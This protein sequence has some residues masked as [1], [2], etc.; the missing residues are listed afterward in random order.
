MM[1]HIYALGTLSVEIDGSSYTDQLPRKALALL[2]Y[3]A[4]KGKPQSRDTL[5]EL[6][7]PDQLPERASGSLRAILTDLR[8]FLAPYLV[9]SR[10]TVELATAA[11]CWIDV[12]EF[13]QKTDNFQ[14]TRAQTN[15]LSDETYGA[16]EQALELVQGE[17][18]SGFL[19]SNNNEFE[20]W[21]VE[22]REWIRRQ[23]I[24][25]GLELIAMLRERGNPDR[26]IHWARRL[27]R[28]D[29]L[30]E[31]THQQMMR[32]L[33]ESGARAAALDHYEKLR[34]QLKN[35]LDVEPDSVTAALYHAIRS[36]KF[37]GTST[38]QI[39][40]KTPEPAPAIE[41]RLPTQHYPF[42]G[43][44]R[45][46]SQIQTLLTSKSCRLL[47]LAGSG[48]IGKTRLAIETGRQLSG[49]FPDGVY[50]VPLAPVNDVEIIP[51]TIAEA[52]RV[53]HPGRSDI[54]LHLFNFLAQ[55]SLLLILDNFE[56]LMDASMLVSEILG[57]APQIKC[58][59]TSRERLGLMEE[60]TLGVEGMQFPDPGTE[61]ME[62][63]PSLEMFSQAAQRINPAFALEPELEAVARICQLVQG[64]PLGIE[65]AAAWVRVMEPAE[66][67]RHIG[68]NVDFLTSTLRNIPE[69]H[70]SMRAI[71]EWSWNLLTMDE[72]DLLRRL[73]IFRGGFTLA[74]V[75]EIIDKPQHV[76]LSLLNSLVEKSL[77]HYQSQDVRYS[78][79][80]LLRQFAEEK[81]HTEPAL[82]AEVEAGH[83]HYYATFMKERETRLGGAIHHEIIQEAVQ[84]L[85]NVR[86][87][88]KYS[89]SRCDASL[90]LMLVRS[91]F[92]VYEGQSMY[93]E[94]EAAFRAAKTC[95]RNADPQLKQ[96]V[97]IRATLFHGF[98]LYMMNRYPEARTNLDEAL[99][100]LQSLATQD[101]SILWDLRLALGYTAAMNYAEGNFV[102]ARRYYEAEVEIFRRTGQ[103]T[104][105]GEPLMRLSDIAVVMG[106]YHHARQII[107]ENLPLFW[108]SSSRRSRVLFLTTLGDIDCKLGAF[109]EAK[110]HFEEAL[111]L[112]RAL[113]YRVNTGVALVSLG[114]VTYGLGEYDQAES[115][116]HESLQIFEEVTHR[117][118]ISFART[119][120]GRVLT[121]IG[122]FSE[123]RGN[124]L[125]SLSI[126]QE[127]R[128]RWV[129]CF[130]LRQFAE[131]HAQQDDWEQTAHHLQMALSIAYEINVLPLILDTLAG[132]AVCLAQSGLNSS[133][134]RI[135]T[136][137]TNH[138]VTEFE[139]RNEGNRVLELLKPEELFQDANLTLDVIVAEARDQIATLQIQ[140]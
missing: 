48:G 50:F 137:V 70:R 122:R 17:F 49:H 118:G 61:R 3:I 45:E 29:P 14:R 1:L 7:W 43:R 91:L 59:V 75:R 92:H 87:A 76:A 62:Y 11:H 57:N 109:T 9:I 86:A 64:V 30:H 112:S 116:I 140:R 133:A 88:W 119:H 34:I 85:D 33:V 26:A 113:N 83:S 16:L 124:F 46:L 102:Q 129:E 103:I 99:S 120:L 71:F 32:A 2:T 55:K 39:G 73:A 82:Y 136:F 79:H 128:N 121:T 134:A 35:E 13:V 28:A 131:L 40:Q 104:L 101:E 115:Y 53:P 77:V 81:L 47:T 8:K 54:R 106:E 18:L 5:A 56:H 12:L 60:W 126:S 36:G 58:V 68:E 135:A 98:F 130:T 67:V 19:L 6:L 96:L 4:I 20:Q 24:R 114:R 108:Q 125:T 94:G 22:Q 110:Q 78:L 51:A 84:E 74:A 66:I 97:T 25:C 105:A 93:V 123:A 63:Y 132:V 65:L 31:E 111:T 44:E 89:M 138:P 127:I 38:P 21:L 23:Y 10:Q 42:I 52:I 80:E 117:W 27:I 95:L 15:E 107:Q 100:L 72:R 37:P 139:G 41:I 90:L 69:R